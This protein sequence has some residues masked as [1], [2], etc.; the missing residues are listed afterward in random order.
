MGYLEETRQLTPE[1]RMKL[2]QAISQ[3]YQRILTFEVKGGG[4]DWYGKSPA[5]TRLSAYGVL[6]LTDMSRVHTVDPAVIER[7]LKLLRSRQARDGSWENLTMTAYVAWAF[8]AAGQPNAAAEAW[9]RQHAGEAR[10]AYTLG[11]VANAIPDPEILAR[12]ETLPPGASLYGGDGKV[13]STALTVLATRSDKGLSYLAKAKDPNGAWRS[14]QATILALKALLEVGKCPPPKSPVRLRALVNGREIGGFKIVDA[15]NFDVMQEVEVELREG[16]NVVEI[17]A[18]GELSA[19]VQLAG[20]YYIPWSLAPKTESPLELEVVY[21]RKE[22]ERN[23]TTQAEVT[24]TYR[25]EGTF[26][27]IVDLGI[28]PGFDVDPAAFEEMKKAGTIDKYEIPGRQVT[29]YFGAVRAGTQTFRYTLRPKFPVR[30]TTPP[31]W[32]YEYYAP[33]RRGAAN[34][35]RLIVR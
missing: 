18:E 30:A 28:P 26:M 9:L 10:D 23:E 34:P 2:E 8:R 32:C 13:E 1:W 17:E 35:T 12:L 7:A 16:E 4:F 31:S 20:R 21:Q 33:D 22:L 19:S 25:G 6:E 5:D 11:L 27:V 29:L 24:M 14:T 3:G 15:S